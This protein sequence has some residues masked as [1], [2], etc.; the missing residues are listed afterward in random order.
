MS[1]IR[2]YVEIMPPTIK[3]DTD[4]LVSPG[5]RCGYCQGNGWFW[6]QKDDER[7]AVKEPCPICN[8]KGEVDAVITIKW[9]PA[10]K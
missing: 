4:V 9:Q 3:S 5:H 1:R 7:D 8:G 2:R 6:K 10:C